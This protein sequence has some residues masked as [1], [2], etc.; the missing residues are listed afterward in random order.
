M[1][2]IQR[3][4]YITIWSVV[5]TACSYLDVVPD[6]VATIDYAFR[7][8]L[9][10]EKYLFTCYSWLPGFADP[11]SGNPGIGGADEIWYNA[12]YTYNAFLLAQGNQN[13]Q[14]PFLDFWMGDR[15]GVPLF[16]GIRECNIF[17]ENI[18]QVKGM[19]D[20][21]KA[22]MSAEVKF[23]KAYYHFWLMRMYGPIPIMDTNL[24]IS[25]TVEE[26]KAV[27][28]E[29]TDDVVNYIVHLLDEAIAV[30]PEKVQFEVQEL[31]RVTKPI[32]MAI[33]AQVLVTA[34]SPL[35][36]G[37]ID[38]PTYQNAR[39]EML[40]NNQFHAEKWA[41]AAQ[42]AKEAIETCEAL[43]SKLYYFAN[44]GYAI[45]DTTKTEMSIRAAITERWNSEVIWG[46]TNSTAGAIQTGSYPRIFPGDADYYGGYMSVPFSMVELFYSA[47][48]VPIEEDLDW[49]YADRYRTR[50]AIAQEHLYVKENYVTAMLN[51]EREPRFYADLAFDGGRWY[52]QGVYTD[53]NNFYVEG[54]LGGAAAG[55][56]YAYSV[57]G[58]LPKKMV[59]FQNA[60]GPKLWTV[61]RYP[62]PIMRL[63]DLYL[64]YA[65]AS[66]E[67]Y[68]PS[69]EVYHYLDLI[70]ERAGL[71]GVEAA[72]GQHSSRPTKY[73]TKEGLREIIHQE[74]GI[75]LAFEGSRFWDQRRWKTAVRTLNHAIV[76]W[77]VQQETPESYYRPKIIFQQT[78]GL[79]DYFWPIQESEL[80][81]NRGLMQSPGW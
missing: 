13:I 28:R 51:F 81:R 37:N 77:D 79:R 38:F 40:F 20:A 7:T 18:D 65:E 12:H 42:A 23:L 67:A 8:P 48:G 64:L 54:R 34:A 76:G 45:S 78:F 27:T 68:G 15:G 22:R 58:Y 17:L 61:Q 47:N 53:V 43:G 62:W 32:A 4:L 31:G 1:K 72:W 60:A 59:N 56:A 70:R 80:I 39:G 16:R 71:L 6:N 9:T 10:A 73:Q 2:Y 21:D 35:F 5:F 46:S 49:Q 33:K 36:N 26:V 57:T 41:L 69:D 52:G 14:N 29:P 74:R 44:S 19:S 50:K 75:E 55:H 3:Y 66:N 63:A 30:L 24:P 11:Y 25:A